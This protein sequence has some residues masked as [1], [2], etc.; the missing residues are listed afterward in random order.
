MASKKSTTMTEVEK[1]DNEQYEAVQKIIA[2]ATKHKILI[3]TWNR[4]EV[5]SI[6]GHSISN[7]KWLEYVKRFDEVSCSSVNEQLSELVE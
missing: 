5:E 1:F 4:D 7:T 2:L 6:V 3:M